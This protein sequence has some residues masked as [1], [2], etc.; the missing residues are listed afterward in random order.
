MPYRQT[1]AGE[2]KHL[3]QVLLN[4]EDTTYGMHTTTADHKAAQVS[5]APPTKA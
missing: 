4:Q 2:F 3:K 5:I 1:T